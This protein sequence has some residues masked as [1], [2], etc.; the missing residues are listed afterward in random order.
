MAIGPVQEAAW[1]VP[2]EIPPD[3]AGPLEHE[4]TSRRH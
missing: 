3:T 2:V 4:R 1:D